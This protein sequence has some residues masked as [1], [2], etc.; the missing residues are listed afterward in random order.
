MNGFEN[1]TVALIFVCEVISTVHK[2]NQI[3]HLPNMDKQIEIA[4]SRE[5]IIACAYH[6]E[7]ENTPTE[8]PNFSGDRQPILN[9]CKY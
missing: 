6:T 1:Q 2:Q 5:G 4:K 8:S 3:Q 7:K 9:D